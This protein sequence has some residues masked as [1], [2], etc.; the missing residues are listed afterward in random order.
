M[1]TAG[2][3]SQQGQSAEE[4]TRLQVVGS[5]TILSDMAAQIGGEHVAVHNLVPR[6]TDPHNFEPLPADLKALSNADVVLY[7]GLNL[8]GGEDGW[9]FRLL[10]A[11]QQDRQVAP[12]ASVGITPQLL[13]DGHGKQEVNPHAFAS[14]VAGQIMAQNVAEALSLADPGNA[15]FYQ[16]NASDYIAELQAV[17]E[18]YRRRL[19]DIPPG[20]R[21]IVTSERAFSYLAAEYDLEEGFIWAVDTDE[22]GSPDQIMGAIDFVRNRGVRALLLESNVDPR[23]METVSAETDVPILG[24][25]Y[26]DEVGAPGLGSDSYLGY[27]RHNLEIIVRAMT[28][29]TP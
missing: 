2:G 15:A 1:A 3:C 13:T 17:D 27:L 20:A 21:V 7:N 28:A 5:F 9:L 11:A 23:P 16:A 24:P 25:I 4:D 26:S 12:E 8:E 22:N 29:P 19:G 6:G 10:D 14:P 18:E